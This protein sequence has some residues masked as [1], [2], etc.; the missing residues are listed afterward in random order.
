M[1]VDDQGAP[2]GAA[3]DEVM[4]RVPNN[5]PNVVH[6]RKVNAGFDVLLFGRQNHVDRVVA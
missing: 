6:P 2:T 4:A 1:G 5:E 3:S